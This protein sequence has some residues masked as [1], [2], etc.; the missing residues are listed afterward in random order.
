LIYNIKDSDVEK[1][2]DAVREYF[3]GQKRFVYIAT[4]GC[5]QNEAD[6]EKMLG[7][8]ELMGYESTD[9]PERA[10]L[11][12]FNT[13]AI[14]E[15][16]EEKALSM[17]GRFKALKK[18]NPELIVGVVGCMAAEPHRAEML[19]RD[20]HYVSF[21]LE[22]NMIHRL[23]E[24]IANKI[25]QCKRS[26]VYGEDKGDIYEGAPVSRREGHRAWVSIMYGCN[27]FCSYCIVPY[28]RGRERSRRSTDI[29]NEC[30]ELVSRGVKEI[31]LLG[32][33]VN[34]Y[35]SD[36]DFPDLLSAIAEIE[37]D[38]LI[39]FM[40]SHPKDTS[41]S[42]IRVMG[43]YSPKIAPYFHLP[44]QSGNNRILK[45][46][47]RTYT[48]EQFLQIVSKLRNTVPNI[49]LSTDVIVGFPSETEEEF[50][51]T[52]DILNT[53]RFDTVYS[54]LYSPRVGT[55]AAKMDDAVSREEKNDRMS[56]L[57]ALQ[58]TVSLEKNLPYEGKCVRVLTDSLKM[59]NGD[60]VYTGRTDTNKL[61]HFKGAETKIGEWV[62][63]EIE[64]ACPYD[65][66]G[67]R[68]D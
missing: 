57:L 20:F 32:Q 62:F 24:M 55:V 22:P 42:L 33:N 58:D 25:S 28:V 53:V 37:G 4:F 48:R 39:R 30:K 19:K 68:K 60:T 27:N 59:R 43:K 29:I 56:R 13:C 52:M 61:V 40:T 38:F 10:D 8:C 1:Y 15:H 3:S 47:N 2:I 63:V 26:F 46:M 12:I 21:T 45:I 51:D 65:L 66:I 35:R 6:S 34:S 41:E 50:D 36:I 9:E 49:S 11:V 23:P 16:A 7:I 31:T 64:K 14:R 5:Q 67:K 54:F 17:L 44:L 18:S